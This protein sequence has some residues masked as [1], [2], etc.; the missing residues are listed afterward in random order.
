M[1]N[2]IIQRDQFV[3]SP[4]LGLQ[5]IARLTDT[6]V[7]FLATT[8]NFP[9]NTFH[10]FI[11]YA[12]AHPNDIRYASGGNGAYQHVNTEIL[13]NRVGGLHLIHIPYKDGG[14]PILKDLASGDIQVTWFN[15][16][17]AAS[18]I[19]AGKARPLAVAAEDRLPDWPNVPTLNELGFTG[20]RPSQWSAMFASANVPR[21]IVDKLHAALTAA[22]QSLEMQTIFAKRGMTAKF[23]NSP[24]EV[25]D[26][27]RSE[28]EIWRR[29]IVEA[30]VKIEQ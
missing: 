23:D 8:T 20:F 15:V 9:P 5:P 17:N 19:K 13:A 22:S 3:F 16:A 29:D 11:A 18:I 10:E 2:Q 28:T 4:R 14:M 24:D 1:L 7:F 27:L 26:W 21:P 25:R 6:P 12:K 30:G